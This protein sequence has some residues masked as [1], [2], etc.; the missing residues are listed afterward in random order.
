M[1]IGTLLHLVQ[2]GEDWA[3]CG[4]SSLA[5]PIMGHWARALWSFR[6]YTNLTIS[7]YI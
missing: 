7:I 3:G 4:P 5:S 6:M 2:R 1:L